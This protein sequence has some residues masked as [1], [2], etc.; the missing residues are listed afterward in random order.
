[1]TTM[2]VPH[3]VMTQDPDLHVCVRFVPASVFRSLVTPW[4]RCQ[5]LDDY[6][7]PTADDLVVA[8]SHAWPYQVHPDPLGKKTPVIRDLLAQATTAFKPRGDTLTFLDF[9]SVMQRPRTKDEEIKFMAALTAMPYFYLNA[10][11]VN[12]IDVPFSAVPEDGKTVIAAIPVDSLANLELLEDKTHNSL[13]VIDQAG[14]GQLAAGDIIVSVN[15]VE[16]CTKIDFDLAIEQV[17]VSEP[18]FV[19]V[20]F[21][22]YPY[23]KR[24]TILAGEKGCFNIR[25]ANITRGIR[26]FK[27][28]VGQLCL[29]AI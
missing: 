10:D 5:E 14:A 28:R 19:D 26:H 13:Q 25:I 24:N 9:I 18:E 29:G 8:N 20:E 17:R 21:K 23:G 16:I 4:P 12:H 2:N 1:M 22:K 27:W 3:L 11:A 6:S 7:P 15:N